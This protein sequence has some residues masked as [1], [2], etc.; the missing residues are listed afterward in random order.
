VNGHF[1]ASPAFKRKQQQL[2]K[3]RGNPAGVK[4]GQVWRSWDPR[5]R[6]FDN[7]LVSS[8]TVVGIGR[9]AAFAVCDVTR[10]VDPSGVA[11]PRTRRTS[12]RLD[13]FTKSYKLLKDAP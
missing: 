5:E 2:A 10:P 6:S 1:E 9:S 12:I 13:R 8:Y 7:A 4:V 3:A 11:P